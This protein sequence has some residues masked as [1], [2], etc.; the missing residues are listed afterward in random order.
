MWRVVKVTYENKETVKKK[1]MHFFLNMHFFF[2][3]ADINTPS[4][5]RSKRNHKDL[6]G[7]G[8]FGGGGSGILYLTPTP[9]TVTTRMTLH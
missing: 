6:L 5:Y 9:Y 7:T 3:A 1:N 8:K 4:F 2:K